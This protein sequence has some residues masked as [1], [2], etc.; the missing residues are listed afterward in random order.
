MPIATINKFSHYYEDV[1]DGDALM[2]LHGATGSAHQFEEHVPALS[3]YYRVIVPDMRGMGRSAHV[4]QLDSV[5]AWVDDA[6]GLLAYLGIGSTHVMGSSLGSRVG[7][8]LALEH[9]ESVRSLILDA[10]IIAISSG[11]NER[12]NQRT[13]SPDNASPEQKEIYIRQH[14]NDWRD[15]I[16][17]YYRIRNDPALQEYFDLKSLIQKITVPTLILHGDTDDVTHPL[18]DVY[19]LHQRVP[20][21]QMAIVPGLAYSVNR[22]GREHFARLVLEFLNNL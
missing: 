9:P 1:G 2:L 18:A 22:F 20:N 4:E 5:S 6:Y 10:P 8:R 12:L 3:R 19:E 17:N 14:G 15:V 7:M 16:L 13:G 11:A 21:S